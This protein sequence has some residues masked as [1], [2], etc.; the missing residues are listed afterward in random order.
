MQ[1]WSRRAF[2]ESSVVGGGVLMTAPMLFGANEPLAKDDPN[3]FQIG[4]QEYTFHSWLGKKLDHLDYPALVKKELGITHVE[5]WSGPF[6]GRHTDKAY[7][8]ELKKRTDG[9]G[10]TNVLILVDMRQ[11]LDAKDAATRKQSVE[12][13]KPWVDCA[14]QLGCG[15]I[16]VNCRSGGDRQANLDAAADGVGALCDYAKDSG[17]KIIIEPHGR[18][19]QDPD[20]LLAAM[21]QID[22]PNLGILPDFNNFGNYDRYE[23]VQKTLPYAAAVCAK[24]VGMDEAGNAKR[25][26]YYRMLKLVYE[27]AYAGVISIEYEERGKDPLEGSRKTKALIERALAKARG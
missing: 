17:V 25:T 20:W 7:V 27:S 18:N 22:K 21:K 15:A 1:D 6:A 19:S 3:R 23:A 26:D 11:E 9:E 24:V 14:A 12:Q 8:G 13:H 10:I 16:R 2:L 4:I 5:Y